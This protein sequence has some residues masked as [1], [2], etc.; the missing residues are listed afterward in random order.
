[1]NRCFKKIISAF[2]FLLLGF[3]GALAADNDNFNQHQVTKTFN[4]LAAQS[5]TDPA[6]LAIINSMT[7]MSDKDKKAVLTQSSGYFLANVIRSGAVDEDNDEIFDKI[8]NHSGTDMSNNGI[9]V[10]ARG[11]YIKQKGNNNA[12]GDFEDNSYGIMAGFDRFVK[13]SA[14][15]FGV[16]GRYNM[17]DI[18]Q[19]PK[20]EAEITNAGGGLYGGFIWDEVELKGLIFGSY[21]DYSTTRHIPFY[22]K[23]AKADFDGVT[24]GADVEAAVKISLS[25][26]LNI[27]PFVGLEAKNVNYGDFSEKGADVLDL[28]VKGGNYFRSATRIGADLGYDNDVFSWYVGA[29]GK[30]LFTGDEPEIKAVFEG[31]NKEFKVRGAEEGNV[32]LKAGIGGSVKIYKGLKIFANGSYYIAENLQN[33]YANAGLRYNFCGGKSKKDEKN[34]ESGEVK[35]DEF[36][37]DD[38]LLPEPDLETETVVEEKAEE[39]KQEEPA[40]AVKAEEKPNKEPEV[41]E[42]AIEAF[43]VGK[44]INIGNSNFQ[45]G[46]TVIGPKTKEYLKS[47]AE[48]LKG[49]DFTTMIITG[50][51][52]STGRKS[53]N[54]RI[55]EQRAK[56]VADEFIKN[57]IPE[58]KINYRGVGSSMP[59]ADNDTAEGRKA[60]RRVEIEVIK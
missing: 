56:A 39:P 50:H 41:Q 29:E 13:D 16:Y 18:E 17:H 52:D 7:T 40:P 19:D 3:S 26:K 5:T 53:A 9:W 58:Y 30:F 35:E 59:L 32:A 57:G 2:C 43:E 60:N 49:T 34:E 45:T 4:F 12:P 1:M 14:F 46:K 22:G 54:E 37:Q 10:Q 33:I 6:L 51:T 11:S 48:I 42:E 21:D 8:K 25:E 20:S 31:T 38:I 28:E 47:S 27:K 24:F 55:S 23:K 15:M 44:S 36:F